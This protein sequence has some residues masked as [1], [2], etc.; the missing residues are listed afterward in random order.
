MLIV[1]TTAST[2]TENQ[3]LYGK[4]EKTRKWG[5]KKDK[6]AETNHDVEHR[7]N[8]NGSVSTEEWIGNECSQKRQKHRSAGPSV[9]FLGRRRRRLAEWARQVSDEV[10]AYPIVRR[11]LRH[12]HSCHVTSQLHVRVYVAVSLL[13][14][15]LK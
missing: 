2:P 1:L 6:K 7:S 5:V 15:Y 11:S 14:T 12:F 3:V 13:S 9:D 10:G 4:G 8:D